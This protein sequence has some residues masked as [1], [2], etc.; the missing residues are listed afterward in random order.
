MSYKSSEE[1]IL[2]FAFYISN[3]NVLFF[4]YYSFISL[5]TIIIN[6]GILYCIY[7]S[8]GNTLNFFTFSPNLVKE[9]YFSV[10][11]YFLLRFIRIEK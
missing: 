9:F 2:F 8:C 10:G 11:S 5:S 1:S 4:K 3:C 6:F 7:G